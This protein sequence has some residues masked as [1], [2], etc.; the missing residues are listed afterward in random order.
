MRVVRKGDIIVIKELDR[1]GRN[2]QEI[3]DQWRMLTIDIGCG[4]HVVDMPI[5]NTS[6]DPEDLVSKFITDMMLQVLSFV[7]QNEREATIKRQR[8]GI[9]AAARRR[10]VTFGRPKKPMPFDFWEI[11]I[12]WRTH[13]YTVG[14]LQEFCHAT[15]GIS[16]RTFYRRINELNARF[17]DIPPNR[18]HD[19]ILDKE[20]FV[21][22]KF[23]NERLEQGIGY[24]NPYTMNNPETNRKTREWLKRKQDHNEQDEETARKEMLR[25]RQ[26]EFRERFNLPD[27]YIMRI[28]DL[29][30]PDMTEDFPEKLIPR[31]GHRMQKKPT[32]Y[33]GIADI[34]TDDQPVIPTVED[35]LVD[36]GDPM[37][38]IVII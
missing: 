29:P 36:P 27:P 3:I 8:E 17:G 19:M 32:K 16:T 7:A 20:F 21:G 18:L 34:L 33:D 13:E 15:Y 28:E 26:L 38:T 35:D 10:K 30:M 6:G 5:L 31:K 11:Y 37:K 1:L 23:D 22:I 4:I 12:M 9:D 24:Y 14:E 2:Y 25:I